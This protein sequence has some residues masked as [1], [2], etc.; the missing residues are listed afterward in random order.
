M[1]DRD[2]DGA[3]DFQ[4]SGTTVSVLMLVGGMLGAAFG[5]HV[6]GTA[7]G[8]PSDEVVPA[9]IEVGCLFVGALALPTAAQIAVIHREVGST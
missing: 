1:T 7:A 6:T 9:A 2:G 4:L 5:A 8:W 3:P